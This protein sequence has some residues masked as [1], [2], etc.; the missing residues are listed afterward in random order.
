[1]LRGAVSH[2]YARALFDEAVE[3]GVAQRV[4]DDL[5]SLLEL[6]EEEPA[7]LTF[8]LSPEVS[9]KQ[10]IE[11]LRT[12]FG[13]RVDPLVVDFLHLLVEK[14]RMPF[15]ASICRDYQG[16]FEEHQG[17]LRAKVLTAVPLD[18]DRERRLKSE[19]DRVTGK[20]V[21]L[22]KKVDP[23]IL[24]GVVVH[25]GNKIIDRSLRRGLRE[26]G[27]SLLRVEVS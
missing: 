16:L 1:M 17:L 23:S 21:V 2:K 4:S 25:L 19:L 6:E 13:P 8:L 14:G 20:N 9:E 10:K 3:R 12:V 24:G 7:F 5:V 22:E 15:L 27:R 18:A 26:L 11:F